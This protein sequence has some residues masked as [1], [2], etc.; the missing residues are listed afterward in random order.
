LA[1]RA[2]HAL[3]AAGFAPRLDEKRGF[4]HGLFVPLSLMYPDA[5]L[6]C[7]QVSLVRGLDAALHLRMGAALAALAGEELLVLGSGFSFHNMAE[8]FGAK[9]HD[10]RNEGFQAWLE[11]VCCDS[12]I[13]PERRF[14]R[15]A[16]WESAPYAR[17]CHPREEH[18]L[19][20]HVCAGMAE[21]R[22]ARA[23]SITVLGKRSLCIR[24]LS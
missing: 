1:G 17:Y 13:S 10:P 14:E 8:F 5:E 21:G 12:G 2:A 23:Q 4:D 22:A 18:L 11:D 16:A 9:G 19:P 15:L 3:E 6:P 24:W 20:L 7:V